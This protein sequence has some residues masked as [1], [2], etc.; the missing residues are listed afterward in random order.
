VKRDGPDDA[1]PRR[2][3]PGTPTLATETPLPCVLP[4]PD[5]PGQDA[6]ESWPRCPCGQRFPSMYHL[7]R[8][9]ERDG[10]R[11]VVD[12]PLVRRLPRPGRQR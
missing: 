7:I 6:T 10:C 5:S 11:G 8:H 4:S 12:W 2:I 9:V 1:G 3:Q